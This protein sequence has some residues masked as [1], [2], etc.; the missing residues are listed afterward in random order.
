M[1]LHGNKYFQRSAGAIDWTLENSRKGEKERENGVD[2]ESTCASSTPPVEGYEQP[3]TET[4]LG[5]PKI[6]CKGLGI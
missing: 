6:L 3:K 1:N 2:L 4:N 5:L